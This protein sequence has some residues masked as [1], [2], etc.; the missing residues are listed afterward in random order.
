MSITPG[1]PDK[2]ARGK[3]KTWVTSQWKF[4]PLPGQLSAEINSKGSKGDAAHLVI[5][6]QVDDTENSPR[7]GIADEVNALAIPVIVEVAPLQRI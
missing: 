2:T 7:S 3:V 5:A 1:S 6:W 4:M